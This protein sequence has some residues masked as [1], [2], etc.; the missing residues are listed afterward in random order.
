LH[1]L[2]FIAGARRAEQGESLA[3]QYLSC[4]VRGLS[5]DLLRDSRVSALSP[6][7]SNDQQ[8]RRPESRAGVRQLDSD[9]RDIAAIDYPWQ[10]RSLLS[11]LPRSLFG[12]GGEV[13]GSGAAGHS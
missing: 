13:K 7:L 2:L 8:I 10:L 4:R 6:C 3:D 9:R 11:R 12:S 1:H 5:I